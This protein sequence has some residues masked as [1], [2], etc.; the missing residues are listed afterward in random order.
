MMRLLAIAVILGTGVAMG[1]LWFQPEC[2]G[3]HVV[4]TEDQCASTPGFDRVFC[5]RQFL[6]TDDAIYRAGNVFSTQSD[7]QMRHPVC[8]AYPGV[9]G[10]TPKPAGFCIVRNPAGEA[11]RVTPVYR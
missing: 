1:L 11:A 2:A 6:H 8:I 9:H 10:W 5:A 7:C 4:A 3:G